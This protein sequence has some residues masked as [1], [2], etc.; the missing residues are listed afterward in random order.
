MWIKGLCMEKLTSLIIINVRENENKTNESRS[1]K[2]LFMSPI[3]TLK[4]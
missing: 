1:D 3:T 4:K 2:N